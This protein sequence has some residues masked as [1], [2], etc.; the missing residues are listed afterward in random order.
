M[1]YLTELSQKVMIRC[2]NGLDFEVVDYELFQFGT[3]RHFARENLCLRC[4]LAE[5]ND[6]TA[7]QVLEDYNVQ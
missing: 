2:S 3:C 4:E 1:V 5:A 6:K 7:F